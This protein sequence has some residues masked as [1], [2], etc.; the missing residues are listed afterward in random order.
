MLSGVRACADG[1][2]IPGDGGDEG[3]HATQEEEKETV[4]VPIEFQPVFLIRFRTVWLP[5]VSYP[6]YAETINS[7]NLF[8]E[9]D[10]Y[11]KKKEK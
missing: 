11:G 5:I 6:F 9:L 7:Y 1:E 2:G 10:K 3:V 4:Q 8:S